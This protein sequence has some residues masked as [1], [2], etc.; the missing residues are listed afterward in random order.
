MMRD[1]FHNRHRIDLILV[2][3][4]RVNADINY[5][6]KETAFGFH[7]HAFVPKGGWKSFK[8]LKYGFMLP[9]LCPF[10]NYENVV[11]LCLEA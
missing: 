10:L 9:A 11:T 1:T 5:T 3:Q 4:V 8:N 6:G 7:S 2:I